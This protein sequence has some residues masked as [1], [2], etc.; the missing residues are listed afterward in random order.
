MVY[1]DVWCR[2]WQLIPSKAE[3]TS[4][5]DAV[6]QASDEYGHRMVIFITV[7]HSW[8]AVL[9]NFVFINFPCPK[10]TMYV[11]TYLYSL[12]S[13][14]LL[15]FTTV[16]LLY[17]CLS[18][19]LSYSFSLSLNC[20]HYLLFSSLHLPPLSPSQHNL[21][22]DNCHS[23]VARALNLMRYNGS[24]SWNMY[25]LGFMIVIYGKYTG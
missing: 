18:L 16:S 5:D 4:W 8:N 12:I 21:C 6:R 24:T 13:S 11:H 22:C 1:G 14:V 19:T 25:K 7:L 9:I 3:S 20:S 2:Y 23:H 15:F 17:L 10:C